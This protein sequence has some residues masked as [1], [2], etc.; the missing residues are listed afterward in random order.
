MTLILKEYDLG[1]F[2][3]A[4]NEAI[5]TLDW[6]KNG[7]G[8]HMYNEKTSDNIIQRSKNNFTRKVK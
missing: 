6:L 1:E 3:Y 8:N 2:E 5:R 4:I 7:T